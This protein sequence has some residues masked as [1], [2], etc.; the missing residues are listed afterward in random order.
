MKLRKTKQSEKKETGEK[1]INRRPNYVKLNK[2]YG[3]PYR[4]EE[5]KAPRV[6][7]VAKS[8]VLASVITKNRYHCKS[9]EI[10]SFSL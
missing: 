10:D 9:G 6:E 1:E 7:R 4:R 8:I 2:Y 3:A 5:E